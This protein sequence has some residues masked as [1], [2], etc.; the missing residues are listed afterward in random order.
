MNAV[1]YP[2][3]IPQELIDL[4]RIRAEEEYV[5]Q[6]TALRQMLRAGAEDY[7]LHLVKDGRISSGKAAEL[8]G[9]SMYDVIR[10]ARK[11]GMEL[12]ATPEQEANASKTAEKLARKLKAR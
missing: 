2:L 7:V 12:G 4:A 11:R 6:A 5:D 9:Q 10:L 1:A 3:R 8:L